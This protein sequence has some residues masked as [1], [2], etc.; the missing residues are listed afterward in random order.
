MRLRSG[1]VLAAGVL[2][3]LTAMMLVQAM[4]AMAVVTVPVLAPEIAAA[5]EVDTAAVGLHQSIAYVGAAAIAL[6]SGS[7]VLRHGGIRINQASALLSAAGVGLVLA[8]AAP[9]V[10]LGAILAGMGYGLATPG[11]SHVLARVAPAAQRG[12]VFSIKQSAVPLGGLVAGALF[13]PIAERFGWVAAIALSCAMAA[14]AVLLIQPLRGRLDADRNPAHRVRLGAPGDSVRLVLAT[15]ALRP[16]ALV[17]FSYGA[18]QLCLFAFLVT[19]LVERVGLNLVTAGL[20]FSVMQGAGI[21]ARVAWGWVND[22]WLPARPLLA[23]IG[24]GIV[25]ATAAT[26]SFSGGWPLAGLAAVCAGLGLTGVGW[27]GVYLAE[28]AR[29]MPIEKVG[30]ATGGVMMFT[31]LGIVVGPS[32]FGA[33]VAMS[34]SYTPAFLALAVLAAATVAVL[35][36][37]PKYARQ[38]RAGG[39]EQ[40]DGGDDESRDGDLNGDQARPL[41]PERPEQVRLEGNEISRSDLVATS[42]RLDRLARREWYSRWRWRVLPQ[43]RNPAGPRPPPACRKWSRPCGSLP[44]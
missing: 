6:V 1:S 40:P 39:S 35:L 44:G 43:G 26:A 7:L 23:W 28:V 3:P 37:P 29:E 10:A 20:L 36:L 9:A 12:L 16:I 38:R 11:A 30:S 17:A 21:V 31:F 24:I 8:G 34:G 19:Y 5:L 25:A 14:S 15:P 13:P 41:D 4:T 32:T 33:V 18:I 22:R 2:P 42:A 27:N